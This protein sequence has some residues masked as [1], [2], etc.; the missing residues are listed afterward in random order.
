[1]KIT[2]SQLRRIIKEEVQR[3]LLRE[4]TVNTRDVKNFIAD[5]GPDA[6]MIA[7]VSPEEIRGWFEGNELDVPDDIEEFRSAVMAHPQYTEQP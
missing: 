3:S 1:M 6:R 5:Y 4:G 7:D 2:V